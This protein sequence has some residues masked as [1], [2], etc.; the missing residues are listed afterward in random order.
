[1]K[2]LIN[3]E[4]LL[5]QLMLFNQMKHR[6]N[7]GEVTLGEVIQIIEHMDMEGEQK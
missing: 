2:D 4:E 6:E 1:M 5:K 7:A 3:R